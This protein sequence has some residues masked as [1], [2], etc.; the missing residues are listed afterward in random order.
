MVP[1]TGP[2]RILKR[3]KK[4]EERGKRKEERGKKKDHQS[5]CAILFTRY[6]RNILSHCF[7]SC[8]HNKR[9]RQKYAD[10]NPRKFDNLKMDG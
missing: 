5:V 1:F 6:T 2:L 10:G 4:K 3:R 8:V 9:R 7:I